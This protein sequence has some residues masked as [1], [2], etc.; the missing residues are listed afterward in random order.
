MTWQLIFWLAVAFF[1][2]IIVPITMIWSMVDHFRKRG[3]QRT[4][5]GGISSG[6]GAALLELDR[7]MTRPSVEHQVEAEQQILKRE[8]DSGDG[9]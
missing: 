3:S 5:S 9:K 1:A 7:L 8:D 2:F 6:I 4:G